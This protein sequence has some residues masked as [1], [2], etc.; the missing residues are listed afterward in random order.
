MS[1]DSVFT[2]ERIAECRARCEAAT[3]GGDASI[4]FW[5]AVWGFYDTT[6]GEKPMPKQERDDILYDYGCK[7]QEMESEYKHALDAF[8][9]ARRERDELKAEVDRLQKVN[10]KHFDCY[11]D[12]VTVQERYRKQR[13]DAEAVL[14]A[15]H[16]AHHLDQG[17]EWKVDNLLHERGLLENGNDAH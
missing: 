8:V 13:D 5:Q 9:E 14:L 6:D 3:F 16:K 7:A 17:L 15:L 12:A 4:P 10:G 11:Q 2:D 1:Q